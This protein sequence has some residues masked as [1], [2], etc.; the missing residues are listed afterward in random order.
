MIRL[1]GATASLLHRSSAMRPGADA[2][3]TVTIV[4]N[5][6]AGSGTT[7]EAIEAAFT[8]A[9][10]P[11]TV[12]ALEAGDDPTAAAARYAA[13]GAVVVAAGGDGTVS[14]VAAA[15][16]GTGAI[17]GVLPIG[18][19]NHFAKDLGLP[20]ALDEAAAAI[21]H[22]RASAVDIGS[23]NG[24]VFVNACSMGVYPSVVAIRESLRA[25]GWRK[26]T[27]MAVAIV[28]VVR[29]HR[30]IQVHLEDRQGRT[31]SWRTP[32]LFVGNNEYA[33]EGLQLGSRATLDAGWLVAYLAPWTRARQLPM[34]LVRALLRRLRPA[35]AFV[36]VTTRE[37]RV[38]TPRRRPRLA[39]DGELVELS[40]PFHFT[41]RPG[42]LLVQRPA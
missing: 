32:F 18:T 27:A 8:A 5:R 30:G 29:N 2:R 33:V 19:L 31:A 37:L 11:V 22:G 1:N 21:A 17:L 9:G 10:C 14:A 41:V 39:L 34:L 24:R 40:P 25:E 20:L 16:A 7:P 15:V 6:T 42:A 38:D 4:M 23:V 28:R 35:D 3:L 36:T 13:P 26:W 12:V